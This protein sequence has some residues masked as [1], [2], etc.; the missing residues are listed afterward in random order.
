MA[1]NRQQGGYL[2][3]FLV[4]FTLFPA[5]LALMSMESKGL[6]GLLTLVGLLLLVHSAF[7]FYKI[8]KLEF[9]P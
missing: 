3:E 2:F 4:G 1:A 6:G 8:K 9:G 5:G 7:G